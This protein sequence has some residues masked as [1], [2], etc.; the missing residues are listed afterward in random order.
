MKEYLIEFF[1][2]FEYDSSDA[3]FLL[4]TYDRIV[5]REDTLAIWNEAINIYEKDM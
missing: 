2:D 5:G 1:K 4:F 3:E